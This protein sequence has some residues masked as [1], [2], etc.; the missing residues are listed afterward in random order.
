MSKLR[1]I[2][3]LLNADEYMA[4]E[5]CNVVKRFMDK[6]PSQDTILKYLKLLPADRRSPQDVMQM[7]KIGEAVSEMTQK[8]KKSSH[9]KSKASERKPKVHKSDPRN[10]LDGFDKCPHGIPKF[11]KCAICTPEEFRDYEGIG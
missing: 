10:H 6:P 5:F 8:R 11:R 1:D 7:I 3:Y 4:G 2:A 9:R